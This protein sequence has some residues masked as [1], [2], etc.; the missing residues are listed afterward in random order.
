MNPELKVIVINDG[1]L[2]DNESLS[3]AIKVANKYGYQ[4]IVEVVGNKD[5]S[6]HVEYTEENN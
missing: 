4:L 6:L 1:S 5:E 2:L 3:T